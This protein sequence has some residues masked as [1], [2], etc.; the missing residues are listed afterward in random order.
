MLR[1]DIR[2]HP[3]AAEQCGG[4]GRVD[5]GAT[6][7]L[8]HHR[9]D[10]AHTKEYALQIDGDDLIEHRFVVVLHRCGSALD[11]GIVEEAVDRTV[12]VQRR[13]YIGLHIGR[14]G[15]IR[16]HEACFAA[17]L[18]YQFDTGLAVADIQVYH[19]DLGAAPGESNRGSTANAATATGDQRDLATEFHRR[20]SPQST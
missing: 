1:C 2:R 7:L 10:V 14:F 13:L 20:F 17:T 3:R 15:D 8:Q 16:A 4:R 5:D 6:A 11:A 12:G 9:N 18:A 19:D